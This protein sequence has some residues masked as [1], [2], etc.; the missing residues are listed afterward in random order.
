MYH[1]FSSISVAN[2]SNFLNKALISEFKFLWKYF[3]LSLNH[4][5][6]RIEK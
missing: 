1:K 3:I 4:T 5:S 2:A 6:W